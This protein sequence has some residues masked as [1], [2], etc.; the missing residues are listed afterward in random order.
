MT[1]R[2]RIILC[3]IGSFIFGAVVV[4]IVAYSAVTRS[5]HDSLAASYYAQA[6]HAQ[7]ETR[8]LQSLR[9]GDVGHVIS[10]L[11]LGLD[12]STLQL[13]SYE[14]AV[15]PSKR[16]NYVYAVLGEVRAYRNHYPSDMR[17]PLQRALLEKAFSLKASSNQRLERP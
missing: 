15:P 6:A 2:M 4:G 14:D 9:S 7:L 13:A 10:Q 1:Q 11:E 16:E 12:A 8:Q 17:L 5:L 3:S